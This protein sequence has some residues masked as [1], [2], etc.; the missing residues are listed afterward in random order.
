[1]TKKLYFILFGV[2]GSICGMFS[3]YFFLTG[4]YI[5][6]LYILSFFVFSIVLVFLIHRFFYNKVFLIDSFAIPTVVISK[7]G[8]ILHFNRS[9]I[10]TFGKKALPENVVDKIISEK[11][12][13][14]MVLREKTLWEEEIDV[15]IKVLECGDKYIVFKYPIKGESEKFERFIQAEKFAVLGNIASGLAHQINT[16][17]GTIL[18][19]TQLL[20]EEVRDKKLSD[21][22][23]LIEDQVKFCQN[24]VQKLLALSRPSKE[25]FKKLNIFE[26]IQE[27]GGLFKKNFERQNIEFSVVSP[28]PQECVVWGQKNELSQIFLNLFSNS[29]DAMPEGGKITVTCMVSPWKRVIIKVSDTGKGIKEGYE[30][31][32]FEPFFTT[33]SIGKGTG[34]GL[35]IVRRI[36]ETHRGSIRVMREKRGVSFFIILPKYN[37]K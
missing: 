13:F 5:L 26:V 2:W 23:S 28:H 3:V 24:I 36:V 12:D 32:I 29:I 35:S 4:K 27:V 19:T 7:D 31:K 10:D 37:E 9:H 25:E 15:E 34:L 14:F 30:E 16:P 6:V 8:K 20:K 17:L 21:D 22:L 18:I 33:K 11:E 1:M